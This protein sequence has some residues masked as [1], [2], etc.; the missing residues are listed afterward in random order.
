MCHETCWWTYAFLFYYYIVQKICTEYRQARFSSFTKSLQELCNWLAK[1]NCN[2]VCME[3]TGKYRIP[4]FNTL[5]KHD[6]RVTLSH[7]KYTKPQ[8]GNKTDRKDAMWICNRYMNDI[9]NCFTVYNLEL[10]NVFL[11]YMVNR[12]VQSQNKFYNTLGKPVHY[13][14]EK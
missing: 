14:D 6:I 10:N 9:H 13:F 12:H 1:Y 11:I 4:I 7:P 2:D 3:S 8:K 5:E